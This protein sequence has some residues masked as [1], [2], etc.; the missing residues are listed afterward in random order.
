MND[1]EF[2][3]PYRGYDVLHK[4]DTPSWNEQTRKVILE[5]LQQVPPR[6]FFTAEEW[7]LLE[8]LCESLLPQ[9]DR[10]TDP[11]PIAP[12]IDDRLHRGERPG[13]R[14]ADMPSD[15]VAW[16][17]GLRGIE[18][19]SRM[20][21]GQSFAALAPDEKDEVLR[22]ICRGEVRGQ[23]WSALPPARFFYA[24][25]KEVIAIYYAHPAAWSEIG[26]G[27][28]ASPRGYVRL[29]MNEVDPWEGREQ[30]ESKASDG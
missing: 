8:A 16:R 9:P 28:P 17:K 10:P 22:R 11:V 25:L 27:G 23:A 18:E 7:L 4:Q 14:Y 13:F 30:S 24:A 2:A 26:F 29:G 15:D 3:S 20:L 19:E 1:G 5:R 21:F 12:W 6:R